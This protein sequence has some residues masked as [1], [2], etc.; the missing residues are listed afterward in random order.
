MASVKALN[1]GPSRRIRCGVPPLSWPMS[2]PARAWKRSC[3]RKWSGN[4]WKY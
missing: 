2:C 3:R 4:I 1:S